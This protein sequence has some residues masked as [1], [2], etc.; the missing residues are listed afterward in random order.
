M[1]GFLDHLTGPEVS[2]S[3]FYAVPIAWAVWRSG[4]VV[5]LVASGI[6]AATWYGVD[7]MSRT[8]SHAWIPVW[9]S[10][11]RL[12]FFV[13]IAALLARLHADVRRLSVLADTDTLTGVYNSRGFLERLAREV[14][15]AR[16]ESHPIT[17][18]ALDLDNF[19][20]VNDRWGHEAG[21][22]ALRI[23]A[24]VLA[25]GGRETDLVGRT[26]G[27]E[28]AVAFLEARAL[29]VGPLLERFRRAVRDRMQAA[30]FPVTIS[31][32][33]VTFGAP[34]PDPEEMFR[35]VDRLLYAV[36]RKGKDDWIHEVGPT[37]APRETA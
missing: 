35:Q 36:K 10:G 22:R 23:L 7:V 34:C 3:I 2:F 21:D 1:T 37:G 27:D 19:K 13:T 17:L 5:G 11:V 8:P 20:E 30:E 26:G 31:L 16:R 6:G 15:R 24:D 12:A 18:A 28:F 32:G 29:D 25:A 14:D 33:A 4:T 9:N